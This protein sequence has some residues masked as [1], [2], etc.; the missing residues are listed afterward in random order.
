VGFGGAGADSVESEFS[1]VRIDVGLIQDSACSPR[2]GNGLSRASLYFNRADF[3]RTRRLWWF[4]IKLQSLLEIFKSFF[5]GLALAGYIRL[6]ALE[7]YQLPSRQ[8]VAA[9][10]RFM[11]LFCHSAEAG[12]RMG[13]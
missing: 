8:T 3:R 5:F 11:T 10:D 1:P 12:T 9:N 2:K 7:T 4:E 6:Q 13:H